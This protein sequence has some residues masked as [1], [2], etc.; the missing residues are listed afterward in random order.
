MTIH[1]QE[2]SVDATISSAELTPVSWHLA[3]LEKAGIGLWEWDFTAG[4]GQGSRGLCKLLGLPD[5]ACALGPDGLLSFVHPDDRNRYQQSIHGTLDGRSTHNLEYR[6]LLP[7][8]SVRWLLDRAQLSLAENGE[9]AK[10]VGAVIDVTERKHEEIARRELAGKQAD[11]TAKALALQETE[12]RLEAILDH[13]PAV[14]YVKDLD[15]TITLVKK[16]FLELFG[17][18]RED[19][20]GKLG[21]SLISEEDMRVI[22]THDQLVVDQN[23]PLQFEEQVTVHGETRTYLSIKFPL[24]DAIGAT[25]AVCGISTDITDRKLAEG[26]LKDSSLDLH[27]AIDEINQFT[28]SISHNMRSPLR[29][30]IGNVRFLREELGDRLDKAADERL[31]RMEASALTLG[32]LVDDLLS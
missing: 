28:Y 20:I 5:D 23:A 4:E 3:A 13:A 6:V 12:H 26:I 2:S 10:I 15:G 21:T 11:R 9:P 31:G 24:T 27:R 1:A 25:Y 30:V 18:E 32:D 7:D 8:Q 22:R 19:V 16:A 14:V 17:V 29:G